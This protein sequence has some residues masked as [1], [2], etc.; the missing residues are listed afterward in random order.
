MIGSILIE[1]DKGEQ[2]AP[3]S[4]L[5][6]IDQITVFYTQLGNANAGSGQFT[7]SGYCNGDT[8]PDLILTLTVNSQKLVNSQLQEQH[9][10]LLNK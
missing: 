10:I 7:Y 1:N 3:L 4:D 9:Y 5:Y 8:A 6:L 2:V